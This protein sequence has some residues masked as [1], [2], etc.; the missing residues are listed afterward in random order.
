MGPKITKISQQK[1]NSRVNIYLDGKFA[2]GLSKKTLADF[3]LYNGKVISKKEIEKILEKDQRVKALEKSFRW[4][5]VRQ[6]SRREIE[7]KLKEKGFTK[8]VIQK[9][10]KKLKDLDYLDDEKFAHAWLEARKLSGKGKFIIQ[11]ELKEKGL[12]ET[13]IKK[14]L[15]EYKKE[16]E[17]EHGLELAKKKI[18]TYQN[19]K[20]FEQKQKLAR[21]LASRGFSWENIFEMMKELFK[22]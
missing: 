17:I 3:D 1:R 15:E 11:K 7:K 19:L 12:N 6:R 14:I 13:L 2:F 18:K 4:L 22:I 8:K 20:P 21:Y 10:L 5:A 16:E 9:T